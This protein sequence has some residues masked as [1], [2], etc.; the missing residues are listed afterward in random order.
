MRGVFRAGILESIGEI[1]LLVGCRQRKANYHDIC[2]LAIDGFEA[3][4]R[5]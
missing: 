5:H 3:R 4:Y 2:S 1:R